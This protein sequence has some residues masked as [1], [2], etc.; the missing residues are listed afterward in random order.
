MI[1]IGRIVVLFKLRN[2]NKCIGHKEIINIIIFSVL[3]KKS[4]MVVSAVET[5]LLPDLQICHAL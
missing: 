5:T 4:I 1:V 2:R 3:S